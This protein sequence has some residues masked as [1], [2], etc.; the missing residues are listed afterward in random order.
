MKLLVQSASAL[1]RKLR[2]VS[3]RTKLYQGFQSHCG[4]DVHL[5]AGYRSNSNKISYLSHPLR[6]WCDSPEKNPGL[7]PLL[8]GPDYQYI[9][10]IDSQYS[11]IKH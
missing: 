9:I 8:T 7:P 10:S 1:L 4:V 11:L 6:E 2:R 5:F 3:E